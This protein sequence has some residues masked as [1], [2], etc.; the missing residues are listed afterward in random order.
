MLIVILGLN[1]C[2][3]IPLLTD[4]VPLTIH[5]S[6]CYRSLVLIPVVLDSWLQQSA[7]W[8]FAELDTTVLRRVV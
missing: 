3:R 8:L 5:M 4:L 7:K 2:N 6:L 1:D